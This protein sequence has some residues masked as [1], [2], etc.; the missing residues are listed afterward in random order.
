MH[1]LVVDEGL[2]VG[3]DPEVA[4][5]LVAPLHLVLHS[6]PGLDSLA[7]AAQRL[8][9]RPQRDVGFARPSAADLLER[10]AGAP[11]EGGIDPDD[12]AFGIGDDDAVGGSFGDL[13][14]APDVLLVPA[15]LGHVLRGAENPDHLA[16]AHFRRAGQAP[17]PFGPV[18]GDEGKRQRVRRALRPQLI[19]GGNDLRPCVRPVARDGIL[20]LRLPAAG[21][22]SVELIDRRRPVELLSVEV[23]LPAA[24][25]RRP[26]DRLVMASAPLFVGHVAHLRKDLAARSG[27]APLQPAI[28]AVLVPAADDVASQRLAGPHVP[29]GPVRPL[30]VLGVDQVRGLHRQQLLHA[31]AQHILP[32]A[33]RPPHPPVEP[34]DAK[35]L[36]GHFEE[37]DAGVVLASRR[38]PEGDGRERAADEGGLRG[39][40]WGAPVPLQ[41]ERAQRRVM[42]LDRK[43]HL[44]ARARLRLLGLAQGAADLQRAL[45]IVGVRQRDAPASASKPGGRLDQR[46][47]CPPRETRAAVRLQGHCQDPTEDLLLGD[48]AVGGFRCFRAV[49]HGCT[50]IH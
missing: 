16:V 21:L 31:P 23:D 10:E 46:L 24:D 19:D 22:Q 17:P 43:A 7:H 36:D 49:E 25:A 8:E 39:T 4:T 9:V 28:A 11:G 34:D 27:G 1:A 45:G 26:L 32:G 3:L 37:L 40:H 47:N 38:Q 29:Q 5:F 14:Q 18:A 42:G 15:L 50:L 2:Q 35:R 33:V 44:A 6:A 20:K 13:A 12:T 30:R 41:Q 48:G